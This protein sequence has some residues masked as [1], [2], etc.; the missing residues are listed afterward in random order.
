MNMMPCIHYFP[1]LVDGLLRIRG[2]SRPSLDGHGAAR[3]FLDYRYVSREDRPLK[4][5]V[6]SC[7]PVVKNGLQSGQAYIIRSGVTASPTQFGVALLTVP[8]SNL[9]WI[10]RACDERTDFKD[11]NVGPRL[12]T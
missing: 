4:L 12:L 8:S 5:S 7:L 6:Q 11:L 2:R 3:W 10:G 9:N 1:E